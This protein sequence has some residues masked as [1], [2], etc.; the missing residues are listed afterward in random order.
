MSALTLL[1]THSS[2][3]DES[4]DQEDIYMPP[5]RRGFRIC[6]ILVIGLFLLLF[7]GWFVALDLYRHP[8]V[9]NIPG[10][11]S[12]HPFPSQIFERVK[13]VFE[14]DERYTGPSNQTHQNW[15]HLVAAHDALYLENPEKYGLIEGAGPP[16]KHENMAHPNLVRFHYWQVKGGRPIVGGY[17]EASWDAH[18]D[19]CFDYLRQAISCGNGFTIEGHTPLIVKGEHGEASTVTGW[20]VEHNCINFEALRAFQIEQERRYNMTWQGY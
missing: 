12:S 2:S 1:H 16:F 3:D 19:H 20:G 5:Q 11:S 8:R 4:R 17:S 10:L 18:M 6:N 7:P 9:V 13:K 14:P 15:D